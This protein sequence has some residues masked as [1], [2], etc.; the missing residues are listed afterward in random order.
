MLLN[1]TIKT[2]VILSIFGIITGCA[3]TN[4]L[5]DINEKNNDVKKIESIIF[6]QL[7]LPKDA[8]I[9]AETSLI[10]GE[11]ENW[12]GRIELFSNM[13]NFEASSYFNSEYPKLGWTLISSTKSKF[14]ILVFS[15]TTK[16]AT[17]EIAEAGPLSAKTKI[18]IT[19]SPKI[20]ND[21]S[22]Q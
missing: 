1:F 16:T 8:K 18:V 21:K 13:E 9:S 11:G 14:T 17:I 4:N 20:I 10:L 15:N 7:S 22:R 12:A 2:I 5:A 3:S 19:V 6:N